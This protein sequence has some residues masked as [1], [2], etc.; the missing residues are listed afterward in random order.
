[1]NRHIAGQ[2]TPE[3]HMGSP[4]T[5]QTSQQYGMKELKRGAL[6]LTCQSIG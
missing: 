4:E 5:P 6:N 2:E 3:Y 1:M